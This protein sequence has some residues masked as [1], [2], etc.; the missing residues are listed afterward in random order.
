MS[1]TYTLTGTFIEACNCTVICPCW[2]DDEP[3]EQ[4]CAGLFAWRFA[5]GSTIDGLDVSGGTL[6][7]VTVHGDARRGGASESALYV[8]GV[9]DAAVSPLL[10]A[11]AGRAGG[12]LMRLARVTGDV[13]DEGRADIELTEVGDGWSIRVRTLGGG[14][15]VRADGQGKR[16]DANPTRL[17]LND[18]ALHL[19][20]GI[21]DNP[22]FASET[23]QLAID[24]SALPG[25]PLDVTGRS[26]MTGPFRYHGTGDPGDDPEIAHDAENAQAD[27]GLDGD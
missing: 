26:G 10:R 7:S 22:V 20:L 3:S 11:F 14:D 23:S 9:P 17:S 13:V 12:P 2:V 15:L 4:F 19:E 18:T 27:A 1:L 21:G 5:A 24:V 6:V 8:D 16:F 25:P